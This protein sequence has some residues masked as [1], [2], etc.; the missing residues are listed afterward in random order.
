MEKFPKFFKNVAKVAA[1]SAIGLMPNQLKGQDTIKDNGKEINIENTIELKNQIFS[2]VEIGY[3]NGILRNTQENVYFFRLEKDG[4]DITYDLDANYDKKKDENPTIEIDYI[5]GKSNYILQ[6]GKVNKDIVYNYED[7]SLSSTETKPYEDFAAENMI[8]ISE[9]YGKN[10]ELVNFRKIND[11]EKNQI[12][13]DI[14][15]FF[16]NIDT[17][18]INENLKNLKN[19]EQKLEL[20]KQKEKNEQIEEGEI[21]NIAKKLLE[22]FKGPNNLEGKVYNDMYMMTTLSQG[23]YSYRYNNNEVY[24]SFLDTE[25]YKNEVHIKINKNEINKARKYK[26]TDQGLDIKNLSNQETRKIIEDAFSEINK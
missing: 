4:Y 16:K 18:G 26:K 23:I 9:L 20:E 25:G 21:I 15:K 19:G 17:I 7:K 12:L 11:N 3:K 10:K 5:N 13:I 14:R 6:K 22:Y 1:V 2:E 8:I 24:V